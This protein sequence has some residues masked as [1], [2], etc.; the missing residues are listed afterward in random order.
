[1]SIGGTI[2]GPRFILIP[3]R[4]TEQGTSVGDKTSASYREVTRTVRMHP[5][6]ME[7]LGIAEGGRVQIHNEHGTIEVSCVVAAR[8]ELPVG[9]LFIAYGPESSRLMGGGT[10][11]TGMPESK[12]IEVEVDPR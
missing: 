11:G 5:G 6:D 9:V 3:G 8:D 12:G 4:S 7:R 2:T 1:M 10:E